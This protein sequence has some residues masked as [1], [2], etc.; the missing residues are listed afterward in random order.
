[1]RKIFHTNKKDL[2]MD[3]VKGRLTNF[4]QNYSLFETSNRFIIIF[5]AE[6]DFFLIH[7]EFRKMVQIHSVFFVLKL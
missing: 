2:K 1:M 3:S 6:L 5:N 4:E 7:G